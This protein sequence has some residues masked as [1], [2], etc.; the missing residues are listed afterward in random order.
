MS[1][2]LGLPSFDVVT[3]EIIFGVANVI[4]SVFQMLLDCISTLIVV[5]LFVVVFFYFVSCFVYV[6]VRV[7]INGEGLCGLDPTGKQ[8]TFMANVGHKM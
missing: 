1:R 7:K 6:C 5:C 3:V 2:D 8:G 4:F